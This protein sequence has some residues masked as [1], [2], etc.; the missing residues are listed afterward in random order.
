MQ[1]REGKT[2]NRQLSGRENFQGAKHVETPFG[3]QKPLISYSTDGVGEGG[4]FK[5][6][7]GRLGQFQS[8]LHGHGHMPWVF[9]GSSQN[10]TCLLYLY[11]MP[12]RL[13]P[14]RWGDKGRVVVT[15]K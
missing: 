10:S 13:Q 8:E 6:D 7:K 4:F 11:Q 12:L 9:M 5:S 14:L 1:F 15:V 2:R 3:K